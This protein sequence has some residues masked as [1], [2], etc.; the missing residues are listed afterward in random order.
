MPQKTTYFSIQNSSSGKLLS[1]KCPGFKLGKQMLKNIK[2]N[3]MS[4]YFFKTI[5]VLT[6]NEK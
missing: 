5:L 3:L 1:L 6:N 2:S 4:S